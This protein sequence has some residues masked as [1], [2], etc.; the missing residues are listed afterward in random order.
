MVSGPKA[1]YKGSGTINGAGDYAFL[2]T[3]N[4]GQQN[5]GGGVDRLRIKIWDKASGNVVYDNQ[6]H[7]DDDTAAS[8]AIEG[9]SI[10]ILKK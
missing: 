10:M 7:S 3:A 8:D 1:Q 2:L 4:D 6:S 9:G 5:G